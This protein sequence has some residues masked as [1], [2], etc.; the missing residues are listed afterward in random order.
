MKR[1]AIAAFL[2]ALPFS[3]FAQ[4]AHRYIVGTHRPF[5]EAIRAISEEPRAPRLREGV[6]GYDVINA[7]AADLTDTEAE[8]LRQ[9]PN[10]T[11]VEPA[12]ERHMLS[13]S[14][15]PGQQTTPFG[16]SMV[17][18]PG[19]WPITKGKS[20]DPNQPIRVA[21]I[22]TGIDYNNPE[23]QHAFKGGHNFITGSD[24]PLDDEGHGS[25]V[26]GTIA[27]A[28]DGAGV[29]GIAPDVEIYSLKVLDQCGSG[30]S[31]NIIAALDWVA[32]KKAAIGGNWILNL[33]LGSTSPSTA[34]RNAFQHI[35]DLGI[36]AFAAAGNDYDPTAPVL[37]LDYPAGYPTVVSV[38]AIDSSKTVASFSN[39]G[40]NLDLSAPGVS[41]LSTVVTE[42]V[43]TSGGAHYAASLAGALKPSGSSDSNVCLALP[44]MNGHVV[45]SGRGQVADFPPNVRGNIALIERGDI[46]FLQKAQNA[47]N[48]GATG[49]IF[50][51]NKVEDSFAPGYTENANGSMPATP[52]TVMLSQA[53]GQA[54][55]AAVNST[56][57]TVTTS[58]GFETFA[59]YQGTSMATP[60]A[61][62]SAALVWAVKPGAS[63]GDVTNALEQTAEDLG[64]P[65]QD[66]NY[67][68]GLVNALA[69][70]KQ[71]NPTA[72][73]APAQ[74]PATHYTGRYPGRRGH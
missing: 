11:Y 52:P 9:S 36:L 39:R 55:L 1:F 21:I 18:A 45:A 65:G 22:D 5:R 50:Y 51:D 74:P 69:A 24:D 15:V 28:D 27:A 63:L 42:Q 60:H 54:L 56:N 19:V 47:M 53:D 23:L 3:A 57:V 14:V 38:G 64:D 8:Q 40:T 46:T 35:S 48:A 44:V 34:E 32:A 20:L 62:G 58:F 73:S 49:V 26:A 6:L 68:Y 13:D 4:S 70:A 66:S 7:F 10:V 72:F 29:V 61:V 59:L 33:S 41:V 71:L 37:G 43:S 16:V 67:G 30:D 25:H 31:S 2:I 17:N 12:V